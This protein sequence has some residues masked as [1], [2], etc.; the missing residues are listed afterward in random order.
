MRTLKE[1]LNFFYCTPLGVKTS[2]AESKR[3]QAN[4]ENSM[5][6]ERPGSLVKL[7]RFIPSL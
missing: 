7:V 6:T 2:E 5:K 4:F 1:Q 3:R